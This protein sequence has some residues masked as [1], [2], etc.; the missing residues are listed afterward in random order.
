MIQDLEQLAA[1]LVGKDWLWF[2][3][4]RVKRAM[5][6]E[7]LRRTAGNYTRAAELLGVKRQ[8]VQQMVTRFE[9]AEW[10]SRVRQQG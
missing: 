3:Q 8:A 5:L 7:A 2:T 1:S 4:D 10:A 9:L 6:T